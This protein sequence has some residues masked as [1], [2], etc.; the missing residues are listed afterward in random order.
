MF[1]QHDPIATVAVRDL[2][3]AKTFYETK[4]GLVLEPGDD[5]EVLSFRA[6]KTMLFVYRSEFAR[7]NQAT[8]VTWLV[9][10][11]LDETVRELRARGIA[12]EHYEMPHAKLEGDVHVMGD[13]RVAWFKDPDGNILNVGSRT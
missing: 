8:G 9:G 5:T 11:S 10:D 12:F 4:V 1:G 2:D 13:M 3:V 6:G 7:T